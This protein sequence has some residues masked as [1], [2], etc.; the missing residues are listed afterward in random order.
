MVMI[1]DRP[2]V[3]A[4]RAV[5]GHGEGGLIMGVH[6]RCAIGPLVERTTRPS[7][8]RS[9]GAPAGKITA[10][11]PVHNSAVAGIAVDNPS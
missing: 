8:L 5:P 9:F 3:T 4:D 10:R 11:R 2:P 7:Q 6:H 1:G